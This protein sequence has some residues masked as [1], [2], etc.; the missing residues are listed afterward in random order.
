MGSTE[1]F[2]LKRNFKV[3]FSCFQQDNGRMF[4]KNT[5]Y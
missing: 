3:A 5:G 1:N 4:C 2:D